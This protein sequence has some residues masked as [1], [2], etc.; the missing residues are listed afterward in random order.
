[1]VTQFLLKGLETGAD[2]MLSVL[3]LLIAIFRIKSCFSLPVGVNELG[4]EEGGKGRVC[5]IP[6]SY[7]TTY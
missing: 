3:S 6:L 4:I 7:L 1:M 2:Q 5:V